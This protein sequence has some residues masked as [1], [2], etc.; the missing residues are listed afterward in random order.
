MK[1]RALRQAQGPQAQGPQAQ[2]SSSSELGAPPPGVRLK[3]MVIN[4]PYARF[5][6]SLVGTLP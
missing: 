3:G 1:F 4:Q 5:L 2:G 6:L